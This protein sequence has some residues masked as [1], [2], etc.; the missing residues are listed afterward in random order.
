MR[1]S[2]AINYL[3][4]KLAKSKGKPSNRAIKAM[5]AAFVLAGMSG[6]AHRSALAQ[7]LLQQ[8]GQL[9]P[10]ED[11]YTFDGEVGQTMTIELESADFDT[12]LQLKGPDGELITSNDDYGVTLNSTIVIE[13][14]ETG[15]YSAIAT[16]YSGL[17]GSYQIEVRPTSEYEQVFNRAFELTISEDYPNAVE[18]Y[19]A[20]IALQDTD[21]SAYI[22]RAEASLS[23]AYLEF[24][25]ETGDIEDLPEEVL[26]A[27]AADYN[28]AADLLDQ[29]GQTGP[30]A[31][32]REQA[33]Y[34]T[35]D[36]VPAQTGGITPEGPIPVE[37]NGGIGDG[38]TPIPGTVEEEAVEVAPDKAPEGAVE[39]APA[40]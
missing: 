40:E 15:T 27:V 23:N 6:A 3:E 29:Q 28:K 38:A 7:S 5:L 20:A 36:E 1:A 31:S 39:A 8:E 2:K 14:P 11:T 17:G 25:D 21:P 16:S 26:S 10:M 24:T 34:F 12:V 30:A 9:A 22:G 19:S 37:P 33:Q 32:L 18:A 4:N 35:G 13:L